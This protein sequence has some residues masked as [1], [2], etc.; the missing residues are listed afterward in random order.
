M[1]N[2]INIAE[3]LKDCPQGMELDCTTWENVT[4]EEVRNDTIIIVRNNKQPYVDKVAL[5]KYGRISSHEDE[6][7]RI[8]PKGKTTWEGFHRPFVDGDIVATNDGK[9]VAIIKKNGG[10]YYCSCY[11]NGNYFVTDYSGWFDRFATEEEK[12]KLFQVIKDNGYCWNPETKTLEELPIFK[13]GDRIRHKDNGVCCT[14]IEYSEAISVYR[15]DIG[16]AIS[17]KNLGQ[18]ELVQNKFDIASLKPFDKVLVR[19]NSSETWHIQF[20]ENYN[21]QY[22][23]KY[24]FVC[25]CNKYSQ[26]IPFKYN[27]H[28]V[29]TANNCDDY[30]K[31]WNDE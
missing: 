9:F 20:F 7:C 12:A 16:L 25:M 14:L 31:T 4:F 22:G 28:L 13:V 10:K 15:T 29:D 3:F 6:K 2:K 21:R 19:N 24:P 8:F 23:A 5:N 26:C 1:K 17:S 27:E 18:W 30:F 11:T